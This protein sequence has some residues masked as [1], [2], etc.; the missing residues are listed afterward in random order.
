MR[1][2]GYVDDGNEYQIPT[3][4]PAGPTLAE[5]VSGFAGAARAGAELFSTE[6][7]DRFALG[8]QDVPDLPRLTPAE[9]AD[10]QKSDGLTFAIPKQGMTEFEFNYTSEKARTVKDAEERAAKASPVMRTLG[11]I[12]GGLADPTLLMDVPGLDKKVGKL[13]MMSGK[14]ASK[15]GRVATRTAIRAGQGAIE[16]MAGA[17][18]MSPI[19]A[20]GQE[21]LGREYG[22]EE[23]ATDIGMSAAGGA[24]LRGGVV[25]PL[26]EAHWRRQGKDV[27]TEIA[28]Q[29]RLDTPGAVPEV[30]TP[31]TGAQAAQDARAASAPQIETPDVR[32]IHAETPEDWR[33]SWVEGLAPE[34]RARFVGPDGRLTDTG[35]ESVRDAAAVRVIGESSLSRLVDLGD[36]ASDALIEGAA[37]ASRRLEDAPVASRTVEAIADV[38]AK[39]RE[40]GVPVARMED[41]DPQLRAMASELQRLGDSPQSI[42][43]VLG[44]FGDLARGLE[45][46]DEANEAFFQSIATAWNG[47]TAGAKLERIGPQGS[48]DV[49]RQMVEGMISDR[50]ISLQAQVDHAAG[51][52][53]ASSARAEADR[54]AD[55][56]NTPYATHDAQVEREA[57]AYMETAPKEPKT[58]DEA[59]RQA[60]DEVSRA[61]KDLADM[62]EEIK[63]LEE[64]SAK[65]ST[66]PGVLP[67]GEK[68]TREKATEA[69]RTY[70]GDDGAKW[71]EDG[72]ADVMTFEELRKIAPDAPPDAAGVD[73]SLP[74]GTRKIVL[75]ADRLEGMNPGRVLLHEIFH[76]QRDNILGAEGWADL[77]GQV[78]TAIRSVLDAEARGEALSGD[79]KA[80]REA[81][82]MVPGDTGE[83]L[84]ASKRADLM[85]EETVAY[86]IEHAPETK[87][88]RGIIAKVKAWLY[89]NGFRV[90]LGEA[91]LR[92][93]AV[94]MMRRPV[95]EN[96]R[97]GARF[98]KLPD[99]IDIDGTSRPTT[100][101]A[102][103]PLAQD[104]EGV[105]NFWKWFGDSKVVDADGKPLVVYHGGVGDFSAF[106][107]SRLGATTKAESAGKAFFFSSSPKTASE[108]AEVF[109]SREYKGLADK[110]SQ[111]ETKA[112]KTQKASDWDAYEKLSEQLDELNAQEMGG[113]RNSVT[114]GSN[115]IP[116][117]ASMKNPIV[118]DFAGKAYDEGAFNRA[119]DE[120][121]KSSND[122][123]I[124]RNAKDDPVNSNL[125][126][127]IYSIFD[128]TQ[129]KSATGNRG[130]FDPTNPDIRYSRKVTPST[131]REG[132]RDAT[133]KL[134]RA[135]KLWPSALEKLGE[136]D[137]KSFDA[138]DEMAAGIE[139]MAV[140]R[141]M[142]HDK[143]ITAEDATA[144]L[145]AWLSTGGDIK[146][147]AEKL[148]ISQSAIVRRQAINARRT[149]S[150]FKTIIGAWKPSEI[151]EGLVSLDDASMLLRS[152][153][154]L[155]VAQR[156]K[157]FQ[158]S[159]LSYF[160]KQIGNLAE[161]ASGHK[162]K[163][164]EI[165]ARDLEVF[166]ALR[167]NILPGAETNLSEASL[168]MADAIRKTI[169]LMRRRG[170]DLGEIV[171]E[172]E[173]WGLTQAHDKNKL[174]NA[175]ATLEGSS[176]AGTVVRAAIARQRGKFAK[177][178]S[179]ENFEAWAAF[180]V[181]HL[182]LE[183]MGIRVDPSKPISQ[184]TKKARTALESIYEGAAGLKRKAEDF[185][186]AERKEVPGEIDD[187]RGV[188]Q[189]YE[190]MHSRR[191][192][193][194]KSA[195]S[196][197]A[198]N[199][200]FGPRDL[201]GGVT[202][203]I[204]KNARSHGMRYV[205]GASPETARG[206]LIQMLRDHVGMEGRAQGFSKAS[207]GKIQRIHD[208]VSGSNN[209]PV[210]AVV[211]RTIAN[212]RSFSGAS[213]LAST[214]LTQLMDVVPASISN[215]FRFKGS[216]FGGS[217][218][219]LGRVLKNFD[220]KERK[221]AI[222]NLM[223]GFD[224]DVGEILR[225]QRGDVGNLNARIYD[226]TMKLGLVHYLDRTNMRTIA[227]RVAHGFGEAA[228]NPNTMPQTERLLSAYGFE[229]PE[230]MRVLR[231]ASTPIDGKPFLS[232]EGVPNVSREAL[233]A[234]AA[235][236]GLMPDE[237]ADDLELTLQTMISSEISMARM[238]PTA[239]T[240]AAMKFGTRPG[241]FMGELARAGGQFKSY[242]AEYIRRMW[243]EWP[244]AL[245]GTN[246]L[247]MP[248]SGKM[249]AAG[250]IATMI[251]GGLM[252]QQLKALV[253]GKKPLPL[254]EGNEDDKAFKGFDI[255]LINDQTA[256]R[257]ITQAGVIPIY[258]DQILGPDATEPSKA[259]LE[260]MLGP[261][262]G[263]A[264]STAMSGLNAIKSFDPEAENFDKAAATVNADLVRAAKG[265]TPFVGHWATKSAMDRLVWWQLQEMASPG[266]AQ[267]FEDRSEAK[268]GMPYMGMRP[269]FEAFGEKYSPEIPEW[270]GKALTATPTEAV[271]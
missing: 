116:A 232:P 63:R 166:T 13:L 182:D 32:D 143:T 245:G 160:N 106:N 51:V 42:A 68:V 145:S 213:K 187:P 41:I 29:A 60:D 102:G 270:I 3:A 89:E 163:P 147:A 47:A 120:A 39:S 5:N 240:R 186:V 159:Y 158:A 200:M 91:D 202:S 4:T 172:L 67:K 30:E 204:E 55:P 70:L 82:N 83:G 252:V 64:G 265:W 259:V 19:T 57:V 207:A 154:R 234:Y 148:L 243:V 194:F 18:L 40:E 170:H 100:N 127:D 264:F 192:I 134:E 136:F 139:R 167:E 53:D 20:A 141:L 52:G 99:R 254:I 107:P 268:G 212:A 23:F 231:E 261:T 74:D 7:V 9:I 195:Q 117:Y 266:W 156:Q 50:P 250:Y 138:D 72:R 44:K 208:E 129:I 177:L 131:L 43:T 239:R 73:L 179:K 92:A 69:I 211:A 183:R 215:A 112:K 169:Q 36:D 267:K 242:P 246:L 48:D 71:L 93:L 88:V 262:I 201:M 46:A 255:P 185:G 237:A 184:W 196:A 90:K 155:G 125:A 31:R 228:S 235:K 12:A 86:L 219:M 203:I 61:D 222:E 17:A 14:I 45:T 247:N 142:S 113:G 132:L 35:M 189:A 198:Y 123:V 236:R 224:H 181:P 97:M 118:I 218:Q 146:L 197:F 11:T 84:S 8:G 249:R 152:Q 153:S 238:A 56:R 257:A 28:K 109:G 216:A 193:H 65:A 149:A 220:S 162:M 233:D 59:R 214:F 21:R 98:S 78:R 260:G 15:T 6:L 241:T 258:M 135:E 161:Y 248:F 150:N 87:F 188:L 110:A 85:D 24:F 95:G 174:Q 223:I 81:R 151:G 190:D 157:G 66:K 33:A 34:D 168:K 144:L 133:D 230:D 210:N 244:D 175:R 49:T 108:Y 164:E 22:L 94:S 2:P 62:E 253:T 180:A 191:V 209:D 25:N 121:R 38:L 217:L 79:L 10:R 256:I 165:R 128:P 103:R 80:W 77:R 54:N 199:E 26:Q 122:G 140:D 75:V 126:S 205:Y 206:R 271:Q 221:A 115:V 130:T 225:D 96:G 37:M 227:A 58:A 178:G 176:K 171:D 269:T 114:S 1:L 263:S 16:G 173:D 251:A 111:A 119:I 226:A 27:Y 229:G 137:I 101:S 124:F 76:F 104:E 105:R